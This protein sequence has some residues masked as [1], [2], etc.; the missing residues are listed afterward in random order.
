MTFVMKWDGLDTVISGGQTGADQGGLIAAALFGVQT[1]GTAPAMYKTSDGYCPLLQTLGLTAEGDYKTRTVKNINESD[2]TI[3][4]T[5]NASSPGSLK[6]EAHARSS[7][8]PC[9][10]ISIST[11]AG[12][13]Y[14]PG[15]DERH[16]QELCDAL[17]FEVS[18]F[19]AMKNI[20]VLNVAGNRELQSDGTSFGTSVISRITTKIITAALQ[21][22][23]NVQKVVFK[24]EQERSKMNR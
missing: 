14:D 4:I 19:I 22:L 17:G 5:A 8:K 18:L 16:L 13:M 15:V 1:G 21:E 2:G 9:L 12:M 23:H 10:N 7:G 11:I 20:R 6:T 3:I 24:N